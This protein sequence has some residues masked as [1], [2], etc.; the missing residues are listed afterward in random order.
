MKKLIL[1]ACVAFS[2]AGCESESGKASGE[3]SAS[4]EVRAEQKVEQLGEGVYSLEY[5]G[6]YKLDDFI[7]AQIKDRES[8]DKWLCEN[9]TNGVSTES[10]DTRKACSCFF[11]PDT[12]GGHLFGRNCDMYPS[13]AMFIKTQPENGFAS[14]GIVDF[15]HLNVGENGDNPIDSEQ[16]GELFN[17]APYIISDG[18]NE[19]GLGVSL[20][21]VDYT[22]HVV[23]D[24]EKPDMLVYSALRVV[25]EKCADVDEA[26]K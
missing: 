15:L 14:I 1:A 11:T 12:E 17:A 6:D 3:V 13:G 23:N 2:L 5:S 8:F 24:T 16:A 4:E 21:T 18:L 19:K 22:D 10:S 20:L 26:V 25:L 7:S 9:L